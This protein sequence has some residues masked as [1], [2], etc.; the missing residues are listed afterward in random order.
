MGILLASGHNI[1]DIL[2]LSWDQIKICS[3]SILRHKISM[4][5]MILEPLSNSLGSKYN[6]G[7]VK[8]KPKDTKLSKEQKDAERLRKLKQL[9]FLSE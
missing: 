5:N 3:R 6:K 1:D 4:L 2:D 7:K 9:G 8:R